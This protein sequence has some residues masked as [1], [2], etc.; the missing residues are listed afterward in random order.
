MP[1]TI[2]DALSVF[3]TDCKDYGVAPQKNAPGSDENKDA[4]QRYLESERR[5]ESAI[6]EC[7]QAGSSK[8]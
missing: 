4:R 1:Q 7:L 3:R 8:P 6:L 5:L 2:K